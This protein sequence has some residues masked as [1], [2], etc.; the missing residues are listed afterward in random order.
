MSII[1]ITDAAEIM[2]N[3][4]EILNSRFNITRKVQVDGN[5]WGSAWV[6]KKKNKKIKKKAAN[7]P[8]KC[9]NTV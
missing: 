2:E 5:C 1:I 9:N 3:I 6:K 7:I 4:P 8:N